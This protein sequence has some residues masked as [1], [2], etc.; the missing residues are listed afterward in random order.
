MHLGNTSNLAI[1]QLIQ[2]NLDKIV[3]I[4]PNTT[5]KVVESLRLSLVKLVDGK[6]DLIRDAPALEALL[7][8]SAR[9]ISNLEYAKKASDYT[10]SLLN[11]SNLPP[12]S[13]AKTS[14]L[15]R[16][17]AKLNDTE[18]KA[19]FSRFQDRRQELSEQANDPS[20]AFFDQSTYRKGVGS[21]IRRWAHYAMDTRQEAEKLGN[22]TEQVNLAFS[23][24][25]TTVYENII[26]KKTAPIDSIERIDIENRVGGHC[27]LLIDRHKSDAI[28][29]NSS[30]N[31]HDF[32]HL[33]DFGDTC[34][35]VDPWNR[36]N[37]FYPASDIKEGMPP[38]GAF[39]KA[40]IEFGLDF[41]EQKAPDVQPQAE[42]PKKHS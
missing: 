28:K 38:C 12:L 2:E 34:V 27:Y 30:Y 15:E 21:N 35:V 42:T 4:V 10:A 25:Y 24:L 32:L 5:C 31:A 39:G 36:E 22:C 13:Q 18:L 37:P 16:V 14:E 29:P 11:P 26:A 23:Y 20:I 8:T 7:D 40:N 17:R 9:L 1:M 19:Q 33:S 41:S 3:T 6:F